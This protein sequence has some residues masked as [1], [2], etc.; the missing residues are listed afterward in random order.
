MQM[1][2]KSAHAHAIDKT[3]VKTLVQVGGGRGAVD[4]SC[5]VN[6]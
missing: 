2:S 6:V 5:A 3:P 4:V 1:L